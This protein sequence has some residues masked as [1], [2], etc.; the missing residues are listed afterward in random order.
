MGLCPFD[1]DFEITDS[2]LVTLLSQAY[3]HLKY[4]SSEEKSD[5]ITLQVSL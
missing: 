4:A 2:R 3:V 5:A 1:L